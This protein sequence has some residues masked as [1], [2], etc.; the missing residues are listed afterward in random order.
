MT[1]FSVLLN[2]ISASLYLFRFHY[3]NRL[4]DNRHSQ[5][6]YSFNVKEMNFF[7]VN[8]QSLTQKI[9]V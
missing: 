8:N 4:I 9:T 6:I 7:G 1:A 5:L 3:H 2:L